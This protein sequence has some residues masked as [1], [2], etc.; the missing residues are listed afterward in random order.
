MREVPDGWVGGTVVAEPLAPLL[1]N[2]DLRSLLG[3]HLPQ[4]DSTDPVQATLAKAYTVIGTEAAAASGRRPQGARR[5]GLGR[6][7]TGGRTTELRQG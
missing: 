2:S 6:A 4:G 3:V 1:Q 5:R 7:G